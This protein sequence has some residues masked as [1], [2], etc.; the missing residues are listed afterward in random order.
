MAWKDKAKLLD[1]YAF[2]GDQ[3]FVTGAMV[4]RRYQDQHG[5]EKMVWEVRVEDI[6]FLTTKAER[7]KLKQDELK[8]EPVENILDDDSDFPF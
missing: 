2:K 6:E 5:N 4:S 7:E 8:D 1:A 3:I